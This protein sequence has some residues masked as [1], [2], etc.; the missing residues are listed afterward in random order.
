MVIIKD[1]RK[2]LILDAKPNRRPR[3]AVSNSAA[4]N[5]SGPKGSAG[6]RETMGTL[7]GFFG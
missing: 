7:L 6:M 4:M 1:P 3:G 5:M 2:T